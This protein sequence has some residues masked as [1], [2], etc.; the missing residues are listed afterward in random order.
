MSSP[1]LF[2]SYC[3]SNADHEEWV[4]RLGTELR[5]NGIDVILDKWDLKEGNDANAFMEKMVSDDEI[6]KVILVID[7]QYSE[8]ADKRKGGVGTE[9][10]IISAEV[11]ESVDQNKFVAVIA[12]RDEDGKAKLPVFYK[13]RIYIDLSDDEL[14]GKNFEQLLRWAYDKP[15]NVKPEIGEKPA[16]LDEGQQVSL[17]TSVAFRRLVDCIRNNRPHAHG[18]LVEYLV[19]PWGRTKLTY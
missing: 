7:E 10:Q 1:K 6:K 12:N 8:R 3:W 4:L 2:I 17:G 16:F 13:S 14:Y 11:Y 5:E 15:L 9:T 18:A 19:L